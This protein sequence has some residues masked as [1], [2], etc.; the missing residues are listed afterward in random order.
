MTS[1]VINVTMV[2]LVNKII[3]V[4]VVYTV[5]FVTSTTL[6]TKAISD[7]LILITFLTKII[8][9]PRFIWLPESIISLSLC[10]HF[11]SC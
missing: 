9:V 10:G 5:I 7:L 2:T 11:I 8:N 4:P 6:V 1:S 3:Y